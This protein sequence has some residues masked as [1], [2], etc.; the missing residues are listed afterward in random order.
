MR[1]VI[2]REEYWKEPFVK[3]GRTLSWE[4]AM[5]QFHDTTGHPGPATWEAGSYPNGH[6]QYPVAGVSW[7]EAMAYAAFAGKSLPTAYHWMLASQADN[8]TPLIVTG[9]NFRSGGTQPVGAPGALSGYGTTD[10]AGNVKEWC[11]NETW[12]HKRMILGGGYGEPDYMFN[13]SDAQP[14]WDRRP[15]FGFRCVRLKS[16]ASIQASQLIQGVV[17]DYWHEKPVSDEVFRAYEGLFSYDK[18]ELNVRVE[19]KSVSDAAVRER[20]TLD[21]AY[22]NER[23]TVYLFLPRRASPPWQTVV[24]FPGAM[25][26][27]D[28]QLDLANVEDAYDFILKSGRAFV[29]PIYKGTYERRDGFIPGRNAPAFF[30]D[31]AIA[32]SKDL[33]RTLD[34]LETRKDIDNA[35]LAYLGY[36]LGGAEGPM[37]LAMEK[38]LKA[39]VLLSGGF[40]N[41]QNLPQVD[42]FNFAG[43]VIAPVLM[44][45]GRLRCRLSGGVLTTSHVS[46]S[47]YPS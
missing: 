35:R 24:F 31:H 1:V 7:Y 28:D 9:S 5:S 30:R 32:W 16:P 10:M 46:V 15:N 8:Y 6:A 33:G 3:N 43:H 45:N 20:V 39:A 25:A 4:Q 36:S 34:Y 14:P 12:E 41:R 19:E 44:L 27:L 17:R 22:G 21:A 37:L 40:Q 47:G 13:F 18:T 26:T 23:M 2:K 42:A 29:V 11:L 38:R